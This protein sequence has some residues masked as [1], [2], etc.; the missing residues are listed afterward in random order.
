MLAEELEQGKIG[1]GLVA[2][3][4]IETYEKILSLF[5]GTNIRLEYSPDVHGVAMA[6]VL[7]NIYS[8]T[9][10]IADGLGWDGNAKGWLTKKAFEEMVSIG[11]F[12]GVREETILGL[13]GLGDFV[14]TGFSE[15]SLNRE[16]G[17]T[18]VRTGKIP[19]RSEGTSS[20][21]SLTHLVGNRL[22]SLVLL[23]SLEEIVLK[24]KGA[25]LIFNNLI[26][27]NETSSKDLS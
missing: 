4:D 8:L 20:L 14:A 11:T 24:Q 13:G 10:G 25:A 27:T 9:L 26:Q 23:A 12:L 17:E 2:T 18:L 5:Q 19:K 16:V 15:Y 22:P 3:K 7:K 1:A 6:S 21:P